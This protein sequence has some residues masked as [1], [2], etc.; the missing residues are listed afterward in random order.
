MFGWFVA[1]TLVTSV[2]NVR[3]MCRFGVGAAAWLTVV[4]FAAAVVQPW[5][6]YVLVAQGPLLIMLWA[7]APR[8]TA[9]SWW[10][11]TLLTFLLVATL[12]TLW[13]IYFYKRRAMFGAKWRWR[14]VE[15]WFSSLKGPEATH[16]G[17][18]PGF[19][20][21]PH[22]RRLLFLTAVM[23]LAFLGVANGMRCE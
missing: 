9:S 15:R 12:S 11:D 10:L 14:V 5:S 19:A 17:A 18:R 16:E 13:F 7:I 6:W 1:V 20:G 3:L 21:L 4:G 22:G 2:A 23:L 8:L